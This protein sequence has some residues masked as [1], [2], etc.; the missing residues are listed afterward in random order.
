MGAY[1]TDSIGETLKSNVYDCVGIEYLVCVA[2]YMC[3]Y[4]IMCIVQVYV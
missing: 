4:I 2:L 3:M 1:H